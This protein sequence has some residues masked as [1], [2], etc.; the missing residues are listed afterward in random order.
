MFCFCSQA[1]E[2]RFF[3]SLETAKVAAETEFAIIP[4]DRSWWSDGP[5]PRL[6]VRGRFTHLCTIFPVIAEDV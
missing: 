3:T 4:A 6:Y 5:R 2:P 1:G